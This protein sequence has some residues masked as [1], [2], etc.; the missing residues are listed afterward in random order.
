MPD[1]KEILFWGREK[2]IGAGTRAWEDS[3]AEIKY[4]HRERAGKMKRNGN[5]R[6]KKKKEDDDDAE[7][8]EE[9]KNILSGTHIVHVLD[10]LACGY[11]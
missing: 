5:G 10:L 6:A 4:S 9:T 3:P 11:L 1:R 7:F 8:S 2:R